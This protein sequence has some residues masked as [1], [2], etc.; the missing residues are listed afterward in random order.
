MVVL[1]SA[2]TQRQQIDLDQVLSMQERSCHGIAAMHTLASRRGTRGLG[3]RSKSRMIN[4]SGLAD[5]QA[6]R[7]SGC[8]TGSGNANCAGLVVG[9]VL[10]GF[11]GLMQQA[12]SPSASQFTCHGATDSVI[13]PLLLIDLLSLHVLQLFMEPAVR[14]R[15]K[16]RCGY[17]R[18]Q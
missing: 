12:Q 16:A 9:Q 5:L 11:S 18:M 15:G 13:I 10:P 3:F 14:G 17:S 6:A 1:F 7:P 8:D 2:S 4:T